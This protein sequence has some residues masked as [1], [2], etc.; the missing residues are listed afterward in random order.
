[1]EPTWAPDGR[2]LFYRNADRMMVVSVETGT[3]FSAS[4]PSVLFEGRYDRGVT[5][6]RSYDIT[7]EGDRFLMIQPLGDRTTASFRV[8]VNPRASLES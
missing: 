3:G 4:K 6:N 7:P 8:I 5:G 1:M 2:R